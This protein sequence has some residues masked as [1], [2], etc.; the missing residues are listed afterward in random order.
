[1]G[2]TINLKNL[3]SGVSPHPD[4][5]VSDS[6]PLLSVTNVT[7]RGLVLLSRENI[8]VGSQ[9]RMGLHVRLKKPESRDSRSHFVD[10]HG[11]VVGSSHH[12]N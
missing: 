3:P 9:L 1:M 7:Q 10:V 12:P 11:F 8:E 6:S 4:R 5:T 2:K